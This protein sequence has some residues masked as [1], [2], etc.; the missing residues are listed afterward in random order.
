LC[1]APQL[2][3][4]RILLVLH[5]SDSLAFSLVEELAQGGWGVRRNT[6]VQRVTCRCREAP[7]GVAVLVAPILTVA[8]L[9]VLIPAVAPTEQWAAGIGRRRGVVLKA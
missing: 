3:W 6:G 1:L 9:T 8:V 4:Q 5:C 2:T 7:P